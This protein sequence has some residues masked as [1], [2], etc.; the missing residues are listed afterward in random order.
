MHPGLAR[1]EPQDFTLT[2]RL[3]LAGAALAGLRVAVNDPTRQPNRD[4]G[5]RAMPSTT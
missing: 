3:Y 1:L 2:P 4:S 5:P